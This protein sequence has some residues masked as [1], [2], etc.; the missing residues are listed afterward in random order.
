MPAQRSASSGGYPIARGMGSR[1]GLL[2]ARIGGLLGELADEGLSDAGLNAREYAIMA[3]LSEDGP[4]SQHELAQ[5]L[6]KAPAVIVA[7]VDALEQRGLAS[8]TRDPA[9]R[10]R[11]RVTL[12]G[13]GREALVHADR[14]ARQVTASALHGLD[15]DE[16]EHVHALLAKGLGLA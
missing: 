6:G 13:A 3:I 14:L 1:T 8:R 2:L 4:D 16:L 11:T 5:L 15:E 12:T 10:R 9:D 7:V